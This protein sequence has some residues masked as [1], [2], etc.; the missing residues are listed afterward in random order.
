M[1]TPIQ[2]FGQFNM[3][4]GNL[5]KFALSQSK[6]TIVAFGGET[7]F[8]SAHTNGGQQGFL[9]ERGFLSHD[10]NTSTTVVNVD[11]FNYVADSKL[12][13]IRAGRVINLSIP[14]GYQPFLGTLVKALQYWNFEL[15]H[16]FDLANMNDA[17]FNALLHAITQY[18]IP[19]D[20][21]ES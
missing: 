12:L 1:S 6:S 2:S 21:F 9:P 13:E 5:R 14:N 8:I 16:N 7:G 17:N 19:D 11:L 3:Q 4:D 15:G 20:L 18:G 10:T